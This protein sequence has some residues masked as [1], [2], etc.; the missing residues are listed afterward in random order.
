MAEFKKIGNEQNWRGYLR[1]FP[2]LQDKNFGVWLYDAQWTYY[3]NVEGGRRHGQGRV[4]Y[5]DGDCYEGK[6]NNGFMEEG[7]Y[8]KHRNEDS[9]WVFNGTFTTGDCP[10]KGIFSD[11]HKQL[12]V[13]CT[14]KKA[15]HELQFWLVLKE[16]LDKQVAD[17]EAKVN[18]QII[19]KRWTDA[20][21][22]IDTFK[23]KWIKGNYQ[24]WRTTITQSP[25]VLFL[26]SG[27]D[28][29]QCTYSDVEKGS[30]TRRKGITKE[31]RIVTTIP[32]VPYQI[33]VWLWCEEHL[34][35]QMDSD[36]IQDVFYN[37]EERKIAELDFSS[38]QFEDG[39]VVTRT[40]TLTKARN[41]FSNLIHLEFKLQNAGEVGDPMDLSSLL[42]TL[43]TYV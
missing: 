13:T 32:R 21:P 17:T 6:W 15:I 27:N 18:M 22:M 38:A 29:I 2:K 41:A 24:E 35:A 31:S 19:K 33:E 40:L 39:A 30:T 23:E 9:D 25:V 8:V 4:V 28:L 3:G 16:L 10:E 12:Y 5:K 20:Q 11:G 36:K 14:K 37:T 43:R 34:Q 1:V 7:R 26:C 42:A